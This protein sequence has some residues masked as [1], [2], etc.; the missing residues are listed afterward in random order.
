M[1]AA[2]AAAAAASNTI[3]GGSTQVPKD[4]TRFEKTTSR[5]LLGLGLFLQRRIFDYL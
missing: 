5:R 2:A 4:D 3:I 1:I